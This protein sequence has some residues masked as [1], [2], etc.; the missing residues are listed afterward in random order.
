MKKKPRLHTAHRILRI[1]KGG[2]GGTGIQKAGGR[3]SYSIDFCLNG[4]L[5]YSLYVIT[6]RIQG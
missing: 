2:G 5:A 1:L 3:A 6:P 4:L